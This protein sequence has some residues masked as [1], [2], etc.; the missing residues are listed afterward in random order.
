MTVNK[1]KEFCQVWSEKDFAMKSFYN[2]FVVMT[3]NKN[4]EFCQ[5]WSEKK[6]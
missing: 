1:N 6:L 3:V 2:F 4:K 5:V